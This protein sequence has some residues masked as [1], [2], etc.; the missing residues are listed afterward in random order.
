MATLFVKNERGRAVRMMQVCVPGYGRKTLRLGQLPA[1]A[2][3]RFRDKVEA[4]VAF[5]SLNQPLDAEMAK[6]LAGVPEAAYAQLVAAG[7][8]DPRDATAA[9]P[10]LKAFC[11]G[12]IAG[13]SGGVSP[14][15]IQLL[16]QTRDRLVAKFGSG[17]SISRITPDGAME[18]RADLLKTLSEATVRLHT[19]NAK[20]LFN[21]AV[22]R[23]LIARNPFRP[24]PSSAIAANRDHYVSIDDAEK[25]LAHIHSPEHRLLFGMARFGGLRIP[26]ESHI[27]TWE[28]IDFLNGRMTIFAP[29]TGETRVVPVVP[30]LAELLRSAE[31][32]SV[33]GAEKVLTISTNNLH[34]TLRTAIEA[35]GLEVWHDLFQA[36]RR[37][38]ETDFAMMGLPQH[39]VSAFLGHGINVSAKHYLQ[40]PEE[41]YRRAAGLPGRSALQN[42]L[43]HRTAPGR[44]KAQIALPAANGPSEHAA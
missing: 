12:Y 15:S 27:L 20:S 31:D 25:V 7:L 37:S 14:R 29:K 9:V 4:L 16:E 10:G 18:W 17:T 43:Q 38:A 41:L 40:I 6:W 30:R 13:K 32:N 33:Q 23:E 34:R 22:D 2:V 8:A 39:A 24:L 44:T 19:R 1:R 28:D 26:S 5:R 21:H 36:L 35:A 11:D 42:A 3:E